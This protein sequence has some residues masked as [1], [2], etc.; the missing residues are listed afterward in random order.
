MFEQSISQLNSLVSAPDADPTLVGIS[1]DDGSD[2]F[3][4]F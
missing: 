3:V 2:D 4:L 1:A